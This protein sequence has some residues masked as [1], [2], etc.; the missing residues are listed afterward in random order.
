MTLNP[1]AMLLCLHYSIVY[2]V[3]TKVSDMSVYERH[4]TLLYQKMAH[5]LR[6]VLYGTAGIRTVRYI[7]R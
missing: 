3:L 4:A 7:Y 1:I 5:G 2:G 6:N